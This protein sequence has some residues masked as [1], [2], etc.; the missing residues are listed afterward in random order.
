MC[1]RR[2]YVMSLEQPKEHDEYIDEDWDDED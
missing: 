1:L 2:F